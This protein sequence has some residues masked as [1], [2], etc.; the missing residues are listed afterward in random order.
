[1]F[2]E[3]IRLEQNEFGNHIN[4]LSSI[5]SVHNDKYTSTGTGNMMKERKYDFCRFIWL[6]SRYPEKGGDWSIV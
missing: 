3:H 1:M 4:S 6:V 5:S 2:S